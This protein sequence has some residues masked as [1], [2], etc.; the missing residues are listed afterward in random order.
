MI[1]HTSFFCW[2]QFKITPGLLRE[3]WCNF[4][5]R[6]LGFRDFWLDPADLGS[7]QTYQIQTHNIFHRY[8]LHYGQQYH[9]A[10]QNQA[11]AAVAKAQQEAREQDKIDAENNQ[12]NSGKIK[13]VRWW[14]D[15]EKV[16]LLNILTLSFFS[17]LHIPIFLFFSLAHSSMSLSHI[18]ILAYFRN[19]V[20]SNLSIFYWIWNSM[21]CIH[22]MQT[23]PSV[24]FFLCENMHFDENC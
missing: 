8:T 11:N 13:P 20:L 3:N 10:M 23:S 6:K 2:A 4:F 18:C 16:C 15:P 22:M 24:L 9:Q 12:G 7:H 5:S 14:Q 17:S 1:F 19:F 21:T